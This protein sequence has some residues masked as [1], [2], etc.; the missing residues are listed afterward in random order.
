MLCWERQPLSGVSSHRL[1]ELSSPPLRALFSVRRSSLQRLSGQRNSRLISRLCCRSC[2]GTHM[3][4]PRPASR[5]PLHS[6]LPLQLR[7]F[8]LDEIRYAD[9]IAVRN[10]NRH[11]CS[12]RCCI[13]IKILSRMLTVRVICQ[14]APWATGVSGAVPGSVSVLEY[15]CGLFHS[16]IGLHGRRG[17]GPA[18]GGSRSV[19]SCH[20]AADSSPNIGQ[21]L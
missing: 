21:A 19:T 20:R 7:R 11:N 1:L 3:P 10:S 14:R 8:L 12:T 13:Y 5:S 6:P 18:V 2:A 16:Q 9:M 17:S 15:V 4:P